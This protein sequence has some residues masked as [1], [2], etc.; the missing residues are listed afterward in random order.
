MS[1]STREGAVNRYLGLLS[2]ES[3]AEA[4]ERVKKEAEFLAFYAHLKAL[5]RDQGIAPNLVKGRALISIPAY[6]ALEGHG[7]NPVNK[8][9]LELLPS[10]SYSAGYGDAT[11]VHVDESGLNKALRLPSSELGAAR[12][13]NAALFA[14]ANTLGLLDPVVRE[15]HTGVNSSSGDSWDNFQRRHL[16]RHLH[17]VSNFIGDVPRDLNENVVGEVSEVAAMVENGGY[18]DFLDYLVDAKE[19]I[20][21]RVSTIFSH[22]APVVGK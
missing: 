7:T 20:A 11:D 19:V 17:E 13:G 16:R 1:A 18:T 10:Y 14:V 8:A 5:G 2:P 22:E 15:T 21:E 4:K 3:G 12:R 9:A 6:F